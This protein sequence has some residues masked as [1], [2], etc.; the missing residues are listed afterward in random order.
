LFWVAAGQASWPRN[1]PYLGRNYQFPSLGVL[2][3]VWFNRLFG[4]AE[5]P[6][7]SV[8]RKGNEKQCFSATLCGVRTTPVGRQKIQW[9][10]ERHRCEQIGGLKVV[11]SLEWRGSAAEGGSM[12]PK[13]GLGGLSSKTGGVLG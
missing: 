1:Q 3:T 4:S 6:R 8:N 7:W 11:S 9:S 10:A 13:L 5:P 12:P 2:Y